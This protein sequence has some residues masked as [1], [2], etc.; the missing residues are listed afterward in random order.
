M[1]QNKIG[2]LLTNIG[3][4]DQATPSAVRRYLKEFLLDP[5]VVEI[6]KLIWLP[7]LYGFILPFRAK[8]S[9]KLYE[10]IWTP[11]GSPLLHHSQ[12]LMH[13]L[14]E[15]I[16]YPVELG[17]HYG[18]PSIEYG[19]NELK[20]QKVEKIFILPLFPQY[21]ATTTAASFDAVA[22]VLKKWRV[23]PE[24]RMMTDYADHPLYIKAL[25]QSIRLAQTKH[26]SERLI[27][28]FH[29]IPK[30]FVEAG[31]PYKQRCKL[32]V[33]LLTKELGLAEKDYSLT[34]QSRLGRAEW[35]QPY[36]DKTL[37]SLPAQN[38]FDV[39]VVCP[40]FAVDCLETLEE[41]AIK[42]KQQFLNHGGQKFH[43][44]PA[45]NADSEHIKLLIELIHQNMKNEV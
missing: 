28:S 30:R 3:T 44:I 14:K 24:I 4:P 33:A 22:R 39:Q 36:T 12:Q 2:V 35:L 1:S 25:A 19:L 45:L 41:I 42:G 34:F 8:K 15:Q 37:E 18:N 16:N 17:M 27:F 6:P 21:S 9:A 31:D 43:Y 7:I 5:R 23:I 40:G 20:N 13:A 26:K 29:G 10:K 32:T 11:F 38:I